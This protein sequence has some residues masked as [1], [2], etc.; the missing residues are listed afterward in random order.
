[1][2]P[3]DLLDIKG[4]G[5]A[6][7]QWLRETFGIKTY[8]DLAQLSVDE[9]AARLKKGQIVSHAEIASWIEQ[10]RQLAE[11][12]Q[13]EP[14]ED[15][16]PFASFVV[17]Y[18]KSGK[19]GEIRTRVHHMEADETMEW[20]GIDQH[21]L[22]TWIAQRLGVEVVEPALPELPMQQP[23]FSEQLQHVLAKTAAFRQESHPA[24]TVPTTESKRI[25]QGEFSEELLKAIEKAQQLG[26]KV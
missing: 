6:R 15:W 25:Q 2:Q 4:I 26:G 8:A 1:M 12:I 24:H 20:R 3:D 10:A 23:G 11:G 19:T 17:E 21:D 18:L 22:S 9:I 16:N 14:E 7:Q 5:Q 13:P